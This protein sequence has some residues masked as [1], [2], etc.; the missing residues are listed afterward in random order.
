MFA[1]YDGAAPNRKFLMSHF[2]GRDPAAENFKTINRL[3]GEPLVLS[4]DP[5]VSKK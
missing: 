3:T 5:S 2:E 1:S 4:A